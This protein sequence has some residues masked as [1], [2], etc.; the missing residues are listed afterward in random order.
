MIKSKSHMINLKENNIMN[1]LV[2][3]Y[4]GNGKGKTTAAVGLAVR[5]CGAG[6]KVLFVQFLKSNYTS[7]LASFEKLSPAIDIKRGCSFKKFV[8]NMNSEELSEAKKE[9]GEIFDIVKNELNSAKYDMVILDEILGT[10]TNGFIDEASLVELIKQ[11]PSGVELVLTGRGATQGIIS[12][13][14]YVSEI[15]AVKHPYEKGTGS[16][17][18][19]E[20]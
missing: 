3:V 11:K 6:L 2:H 9:A 20:L 12:V 8:W 7:E 1:G 14:D 15:V 10:M 17:K 13:A 5:A 16:R 4:T 19:I 18:G